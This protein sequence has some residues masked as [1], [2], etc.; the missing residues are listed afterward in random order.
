MP[1]E[2]YGVINRNSWMNT[3]FRNHDGTLGNGTRFDFF[4]LEFDSDLFVLGFFFFK[5][6]FF[7]W[8]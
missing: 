4:G 3:A 6:E 8:F 1:Y 7:Y 2:E 5:V